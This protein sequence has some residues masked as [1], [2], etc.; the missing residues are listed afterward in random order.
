M[1]S[2]HLL[3]TVNPVHA[4][5]PLPA[6]YLLHSR[7]FFSHNQNSFFF[8]IFHP[9][10]RSSGFTLTFVCFIIESI[11]LSLSIH[12]SIH[13]SIHLPIKRS[14]DLP[15]GRYA[16]PPLSCFPASVHRRLTMP[17]DRS[18]PNRNMVQSS[19]FP[20][21]TDIHWTP[22]IF[23]W[24]G[25]LITFANRGVSNGLWGWSRRHSRLIG[26]I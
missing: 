10:S 14:I 24:E 11:F 21:A 8:F 13:P 22:S 16:H 18:E 3:I 23:I 7:I 12:P 6:L 9:A 5:L 17:L 25:L 1:P 19:A 15:I 20:A 2:S 26:P 4:L